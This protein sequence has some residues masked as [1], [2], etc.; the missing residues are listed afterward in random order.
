MEGY[1]IQYADYFADDS[2]HG[3]WHLLHMLEGLYPHGWFFSLHKCTAVL[4]MLAYGA[5]G[6]AHDDYICMAKSMAMQYMY[7]FYKAVVAVCDQHTWEHLMHK[8]LLGS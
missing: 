1:C 5:P 3:V 6:D 4:K 8:K 2:L 7:R